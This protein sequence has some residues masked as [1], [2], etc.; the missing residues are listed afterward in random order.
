MSTLSVPITRGGE[1]KVLPEYLIPEQVVE[2]S[3]KV[4]GSDSEPGGKR[5]KQRGR[6]KDR[7]VNEEFHLWIFVLGMVAFRTTRTKDLSKYFY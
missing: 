4:G 1:L 2:P 6:N 7:Q 5:E 3:E